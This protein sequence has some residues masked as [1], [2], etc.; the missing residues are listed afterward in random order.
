MLDL[1]AHRSVLA[2]TGSLVPGG[3]Y[4]Y[5]GGSAATLLQVLLVGPLLGRGEGKKLRLLP[6]DQ[7]RSAW[8][9][10]WALPGGNDRDGH[11]PSLSVA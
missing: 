1:A 7:G 5:V 3:R 4:L 11:R 8:A 10:G 9:A 6:F 2:Y